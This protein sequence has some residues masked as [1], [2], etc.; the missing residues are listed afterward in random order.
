MNMTNRIGFLVAAL[1]AVLVLGAAFVF[2][3]PQAWLNLSCLAFLAGAVVVTYKYPVNSTTAPTTSTMLQHNLLTALVTALDADTVITIT[4][5]WGL[6]NKDGQGF[7]D[8]PAGLMPLVI[9]N[10]E[11]DAT[12]TVEPVFLV[13]LANTNSVVI[14]KPTTVGT[15]GTYIVQILRPTSLAK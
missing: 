5:N 15:Q 12:T 7:P 10:L 9:I 8:G 3:N 11:S 4:H 14:N 2:Q 13:S 1:L 6:P